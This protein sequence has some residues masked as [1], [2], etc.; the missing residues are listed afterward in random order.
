MADAVLQP[1]M[2]VV[3]KPPESVKEVPRLVRL[4][5]TV[6]DSG[7]IIELLLH[8]EG[9]ERD[10]YALGALRIGLLSLR[11]ARGQI[12][13]DAVRREG[14]R[15]LSDL[16]Q[17]LEANRSLT[18]ESLTTCLREYFDPASGKFQERVERL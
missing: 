6:T 18:N 7:S 13:A 9:P 11:H 1:T 2:E 10:D 3:R 5:L 16:K 12:D 14:D 8:Q 4:D 15:L 17:A